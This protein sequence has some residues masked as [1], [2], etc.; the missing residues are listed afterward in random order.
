MPPEPVRAVVTVILGLYLVGLALC[1]A[2]NSGSGASALVRTVKSRLF[3]PWMGPAWL[4][5]GHDVRLTH[6]QPDDADHRLEL[7]PWNEAA[8]GR[9]INYPSAGMHGERA[10]RWRRLALAIAVGEQDPDR[11]GLLPAAVAVGGFR[12]VGAEDLSLRV[13]REILPES[14]DVA[15]GV[16][17]R[18]RFEQAYAARVRRVAGDIQLLK[19]EDPAELAPIVDEVKP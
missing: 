15:D 4:D 8:R 5:L 16:A 11:E 2:G 9:T 6:G 18:P 14:A 13:L 10:A 1:L 3:A 12:P 17:R 19:T 7:R